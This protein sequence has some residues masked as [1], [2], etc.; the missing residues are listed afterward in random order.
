M[1]ASYGQRAF[2]EDMPLSGR[3]GSPMQL[4]RR[5]RFGRSLDL[6][7]ID[8]RSLRGANGENREMSAWSPIGIAC[9]AQTDWQNR[10]TA[11]WNVVA[12]AMPLGLVVYDK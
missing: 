6:F 3:L 1:L 7:R 8:M 2:R 4:T 9:S 10:S 12:A 5:F 11:T